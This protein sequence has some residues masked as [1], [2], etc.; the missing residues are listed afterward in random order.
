MKR[1][2]TAIIGTGTSV[3]NHLKA[4]NQLADRLELVAAVD[5][6][7]D[8]VQKVCTENNI[9]H[10]YT[11][12]AEMLET[13]KP[14]LVQIITPPATHLPLIAES[15]N[16]GAWV[17]CEKPLCL[18]LAEFDQIEKIEAASNAYVCT[19]FQWRF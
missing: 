17:F 3:D 8:R 12:T 1:Y 5:H 15:L 2:R 19:I 6:H 16:A 7:A 13:V 9:P 11:S 18:S 4:I 14:D 10:W